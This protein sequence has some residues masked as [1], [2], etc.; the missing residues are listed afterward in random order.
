MLDEELQLL[1]TIPQP[2]NLNSYYQ[3]DSYISHTDRSESVFERIYQGVKKHSL[4]RKEAWLKQ[5]APEESRV[6]DVGA[7]T[8]AFVQHLRL[9]GWMADGVEP[10][11]KARELSTLKRVDLY[12]NLQ[13]TK[14]EKYDVVTLWHVLEHFTDLD[15]EIDQ[16]LNKVREGGTLFVAV[17]NFK[18]L[19]A[20]I[21]GPYWAA[22]DVPRHLWHFSRTAMQKLFANKGWSIVNTRP[23]HFD[24]FYIALLSERYRKG[25]LPWVKA[26]WY[27]L[28]SNIY[29]LKT[30][31]YS[32]LVY[33]I[34]KA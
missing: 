17:P 32:S 27:G 25:R 3:A 19:D 13:E 7:G 6:L 10:S 5:F 2:D 30:G 11:S 14:N 31:E 12:A 4:K 9:R 34:K 22:Y 16:L 20:K 33:I 26:F 29:G 28:R 23:M 8:G 18:S 21:Y 24:A 15:V 1:Q